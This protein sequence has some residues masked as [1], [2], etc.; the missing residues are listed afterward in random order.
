MPSRALKVLKAVW[1]ALAWLLFLTGVIGCDSLPTHAA[2]GPDA[3]PAEVAPLSDDAAIDTAPHSDDA[4]VEAAPHSD[5]APVEAAPRPAFE[6]YQE[7][8]YIYM[9]TPS[10]VPVYELQIAATGEVFVASGIRELKPALVGRATAAEIATLAEI[11]T[12]PET[13]AAFPRTDRIGCP[14]LA[15]G[16][17]EISLA[18]QGLPTF[19]RSDACGLADLQSQAHL[20]RDNAGARAADGGTD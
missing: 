5:D 9:G 19:K 7:V 8:E 12:R 2:G 4:P 1:A 10:Y 13:L 14:L 6:S 18:V 20:I 15:D 11:A 3:A 17:D 16:Y